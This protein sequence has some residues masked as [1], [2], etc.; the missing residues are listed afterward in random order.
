MKLGIRVLLVDDHELV[1]AGIRKILENTDVEVIGEVSSGE[2]AIAKINVLNPDVVLMDLKMPDMDGLEAT[3]ALL[4]INS[5]I[6]I[7]IVSV[8]VDDLLLPRLFQQGVSGYFT[9]GGS[10]I[11]MVKAIKAVY[12]GQRYIS[13]VLVNQI[14][15]KTPG[16]YEEVAFDMLSEREFQVV[17]MIIDGRTVPEISQTLNIN[18]KTINS[19]R[20]RSFNKLNVKNDIE[21]TLLAIRQGLLRQLNSDDKV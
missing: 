10:A 1:R 9:K 20:S 13:P 21:L 11:E 16:T 14:A 3:K 7:L 5:Q 4:T 17:L 6:K 19:Y 12:A 15:V 2:E 8:C 18:R